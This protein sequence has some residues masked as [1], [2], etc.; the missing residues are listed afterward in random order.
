MTVIWVIQLLGS[1]GLSLSLS[2]ALSPST[3][4]V[5]SA[6]CPLHC[7]LYF[8]LFMVAHSDVFSLLLLASISC[9]FSCFSRV[10]LSAHFLSP[11]L[12][13]SHLDPSASSLLPSKSS[14]KSSL[15]M[16][17]LHCWHNKAWWSVKQ[18]QQR[19]RPSERRS[20]EL[21]R[22]LSARVNDLMLSPALG[23]LKFLRTC[24]AAGDMS[25]ACR[26]LV[27]DV[28]FLMSVAHSNFR[29]QPGWVKNLG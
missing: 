21:V 27:V 17:R 25:C 16:R 5:F 18:K 15:W 24:S 12:S 11:S 20:D 6:W 7:A 1:L 26:V 23:S 22:H 2:F 19:I 3:V 4:H 9:F 28:C 14:I 8:V 13:V 10:A 29:S